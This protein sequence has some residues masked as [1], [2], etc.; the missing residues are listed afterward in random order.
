MKIL[1]PWSV[2]ARFGFDIISIPR[3]K[4]SEGFTGHTRVALNLF[5]KHVI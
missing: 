2:S 4:G 1:P 5:M 3:V